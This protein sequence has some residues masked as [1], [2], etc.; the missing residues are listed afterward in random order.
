MPLNSLNTKIE[1]ADICLCAVSVKIA[2]PRSN[3]TPYSMAPITR[4]KSVRQSPA[5]VD[6]PV[7]SPKSRRMNLEHSD[8]IAAPETDASIGKDLNNIILLVILYCLQ[9]VPLGLV[10]GSIPFLLKEKLDYSQLA[11]F[12]LSSYPYSIKVNLVWL[13]L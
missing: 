5:I 11:I 3:N 9:G 10:M 12:S 6:I 8:I 2:P 4:Q 7:A 13:N 1:N